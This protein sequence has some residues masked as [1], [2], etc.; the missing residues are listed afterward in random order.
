MYFSLPLWNEEATGTEGASELALETITGPAEGQLVLV[1]EDDAVFRIFLVALLHRHGFRTVEAL[2]AEAA[3]GLARRLRPACVVAD[4]ALSCAEGAVLRTGWDLAERMTGDPATRRIPV[5]FVTGFDDVVHER[6]VASGFARKPEHLVKPIDGA[7]LIGR[8]S[9]MIGDVEGR[10]IRVL[11][12]DDDPTVAAYVRAVLPADRY[13]LEVATNG[14][15]CL[16][17]LRTHPREFDLMLLDLMMPEVS[18]YDVLREIALSGTGA[19]LPVLV[20][21]NFPEARND[22]ERR[23]LDEGIVLDIVA[24]TAV[25]DNP[26]LLPHLIDWHLQLEHGD[27]TREAA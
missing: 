25:H 7:A 4:Y 18:G 22:E 16:H 1:V 27:G 14:E 13:H 26:V 10:Q 11:L 5:I 23:L 21:T 20:L 15:Q 6:L 19:G 12:A 17:A 8:I 9:S 24:K 3:W 2:H